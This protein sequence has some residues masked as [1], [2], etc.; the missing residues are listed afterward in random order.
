MENCLVMRSDEYCL[1]EVL[2]HAIFWKQ[3]VPALYFP[4]TIGASVIA[5]HVMTGIVFVP[6]LIPEA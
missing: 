6:R 2:R 4:L 1:F 5:V 3:A